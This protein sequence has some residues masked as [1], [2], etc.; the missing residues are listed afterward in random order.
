MTSVA[1]V[2][3]MS[4]SGPDRSEDA[5]RPRDRALTAIRVVVATA[6][7]TSKEERRYP[8]SIVR[9][10]GDRGDAEAGRTSGSASALAHRWR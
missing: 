3:S 6:G 7:N 9:R 5:A 2:L 8:S 1:A 10:V 4:L